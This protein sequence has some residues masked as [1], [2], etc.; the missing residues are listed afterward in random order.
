MISQFSPNNIAEVII[1]KRVQ[2]KETL[3]KFSKIQTNVN[4]VVNL[5]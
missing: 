1:Q 5:L 4:G 3:I 2:K